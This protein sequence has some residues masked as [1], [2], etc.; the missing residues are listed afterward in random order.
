MADTLA[1]ALANLSS[2]MVLSFAL[3]AL[4]AAMRSDLDIPQQIAKGLS[5]Y[6]MFAIGFKGGVALAAGASA[7]ILPVILAGIAASFAM[8][9]VAY[10][11]LRRIAGLGR[12]DAAATAA[13]YG[14]VSLVTFIAA[15][16]FLAA[17]GIGFSGGMVAVLAAM[18]TPAIVTGLLL[19]RRG[20][21]PVKVGRPAARFALAHEVLTNGSVI[22]LLGGLAIGWITG[23]AGMAKL[24]PFIGDLF[25]GLLCLFLL[26]L[27]LTT[28]RQLRSA[29]GIGAGSIAF[30]LYMP[31]I[32][33]AAG[34][35]LGWAIGLPVGDLTLFATLCASASYIAVPAAMRLAVPEARPGLYVTLSLGITFPFNIAIGIP[36]YTV[37]ADRLAG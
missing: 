29:R 27:G 17:G 31:P 28:V 13:H 30:G 9:L 32:G 8:P 24:K 12:A 22:L 5:I 25:N 26:D 19:A 34:L 3:G 18:E 20:A 10:F 23:E 33:A 15:S 35:A 16:E 2:P 6:L 11:F 7:S 36:V 21:D 37:I 14:S 1:L 4:A